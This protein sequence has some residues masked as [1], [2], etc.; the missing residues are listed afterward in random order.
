MFSQI[1]G[2]FDD[3]VVKAYGAMN[4]EG[5]TRAHMVFGAI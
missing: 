2:K 1:R 3:D 4:Q 5:T